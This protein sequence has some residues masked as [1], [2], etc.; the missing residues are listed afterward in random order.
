MRAAHPEEYFKKQL[1]DRADAQSHAR[2][3]DIEE[4][5]MALQEVR[6]IGEGKKLLN[7]ELKPLMPFRTLESIKGKSKSKQYK[8]LVVRLIKE[9]KEK[10][11]EVLMVQLPEEGD[12]QEE[13]LLSLPEPVGQDLTADSESTLIDENE[14]LPSYM[15]EKTLICGT[16]EYFIDELNSYNSLRPVVDEDEIR[17]LDRALLVAD[18][19]SDLSKQLCHEYL[20][21]VLGEKLQTKPKETKHRNALR[22]M[23]PRES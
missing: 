4:M 14:V 5:T 19:D 20:I 8:E 15:L 7:I 21:H 22:L 17:L 12:V 18:S 13:L 23:C 10:K 6:L 9:E 3:T 2:W 16:V 1:E 11:E